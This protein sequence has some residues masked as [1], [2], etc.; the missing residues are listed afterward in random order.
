MF[1]ASEWGVIVAALNYANLHKAE[2]KSHLIKQGHPN[3]AEVAE[4]GLEELR[5]RATTEYH[6]ALENE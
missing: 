6:D 3:T 4:M 1:D 5:I 2:F